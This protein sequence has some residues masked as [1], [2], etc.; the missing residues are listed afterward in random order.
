MKKAIFTLALALVVVTV[1]ARYYT[2]DINKDGM[3]NITDVTYLVNN[4]LG[5]PNLK[6]TPKVRQKTFGVHFNVYCQGDLYSISLVLLHW[7]YGEEVEFTF[8]IVINH[9][10]VYDD[11]V[12]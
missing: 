3:I 9:P 4:I 12:V 10:L 8:L 2:Y 5:I 7:C 11:V 6:C 1:G